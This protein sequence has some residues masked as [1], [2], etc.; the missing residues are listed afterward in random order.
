M[1]AGE[2]IGK[3]V[4]DFLRESGLEKPLIERQLVE[5]WP[6]IMGPVV[7]RMT[8]SVEVEDGVLR[9][10]LSSASLRATLFEQRFELVK[11]VNDAMGTRVVHDV[12]LM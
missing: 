7:A 11:R 8:R 9:V 10:K 12:R 4:V 6:S 2:S 1:Y 5:Q 3:L